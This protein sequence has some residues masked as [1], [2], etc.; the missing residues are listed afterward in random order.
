MAAH[1]SIPRSRGI[2]RPHHY[3]PG[4]A[5]LGKIHQ[6]QK[7]SDLLRRKAPSQHIIKEI[8]QAIK[9]DLCFQSM[10]LLAL[11]EVSK[12]Y[13]IS[14]FKDMN[15]ATLH[16]ICMTIMSRETVVARCICDEYGK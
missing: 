13:L 5:A 10:A 15:L 1:K 16:V 7:T 9:S 4:T 12:A 8:A 2:R 11:Q 3:C 6:Y 14:L